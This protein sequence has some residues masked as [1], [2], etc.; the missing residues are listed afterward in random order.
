MIRRNSIGAVLAAAIALAM[1]TIAPA[2]SALPPELASGPQ[3]ELPLTVQL[4]RWHMLDAEISS[5]TMRSMDRLFTARKVAR[6]GEVW[7]LPR[8]DH[9]LDFTY[10]HAGATYT[11]EQFQDRTYTNALLI[12]KN[13]KIVYEN[14]RNNSR[15]DD[16]FM[17][18]SMTKSITS[19][20]VGCLL[21]DKRIASIDDQITTYLP[22]LK[23][24]AYAGVTIRQILEMRSG[25]AWRE[26]YD[27]TNPGPAA[28]DHIN[29]LVKNVQ[30]FADPA[31]TI[32]RSHAPGT[33]FEYKTIDTAVLGWL[34]ER[35]SGMSVAA[36]TAERLWEPLGAEQDGYYIMD[37]APGVG[38]EFSGAGFNASLR[39]FARIGAMMLAD[40][41]ANG[42]QIIPADW[43]KQSTRK[44]S[45]DK[46][47][48]GYGYQWWT[49][50][51][52]GAYTAIGLAGQYIFVDPNT[53][54]VV[55]KLSYFFPPENDAAYTEVETFLQAASTWKPE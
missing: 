24:G 27:F 17:G 51:D 33:H 43:V 23:S 36:Y 52:K 25:V 37:G 44:R 4:M 41:K 16:R 19:L 22:E 28:S 30:R 7:E 18:F 55:V 35:L 50:G 13:G 32:E 14:Y 6:S 20:L 3:S 21:Q 31:R 48:L 34:V 10:Q 15:P 45:Q 38:R 29:A 40:G 5:L 11:P 53:Q 12:M 9:P 49:I 47:V 26:D 46:G 54:T 42:R 8:A 2:Q 39:D 1:P